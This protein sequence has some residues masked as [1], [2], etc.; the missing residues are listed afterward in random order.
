MQFLMNVTVFFYGTPVFYKIS[1]IN[2]SDFYAEPTDYNMR[3][4]VLRKMADTWIS[5]GGS[6]EWQARQ[7]GEKIDKLS[8]V[9]GKG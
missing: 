5:E 4:I 2:E 9:S 1:K 3:S 6:T 7:I 8:V